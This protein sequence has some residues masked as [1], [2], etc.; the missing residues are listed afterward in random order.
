[1][2]TRKGILVAAVVMAMLPLAAGAAFAQDRGD[3]STHCE[4]AYEESQGTNFG[5]C[6]S[7]AVSG[8]SKSLIGALPESSGD[9]G[10]AAE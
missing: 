3:A 6:H 7:S 4:G 8:E 10:T 9:S 1:M 2:T 5:L